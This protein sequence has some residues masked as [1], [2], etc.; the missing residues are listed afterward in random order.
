PVGD[1]IY[2]SGS[3]KVFSGTV[4][5][6][7]P[8]WIRLNSQTPA[9]TPGSFNSTLLTPTDGRY[10]VTIQATN[11]ARLTTTLNRMV[12][13]DSLF[14]FLET[15]RPRGADTT[16]T[17]AADTFA[18]V[19][20][21]ADTTLT[22][23]TLA[24]D[25]VASGQRGY[26]GFAHT[27]RLDPG[28]NVVTIRATDL[29]G[30]RT[31][32]TRRIYRKLSA[33]PLDSATVSATVPTSAGLV[34]FKESISFLYTSGSP[35]LQRG[36]SG[37]TIVEDRAAVVRGR[38]LSR[39]D[40]ALPAAR[41]SV[42]GHP[43]YGYT[44]SREDGWFDLA[45][46]G[47]TPLT[48]RFNKAGFLESQRQVN[49]AAND[50]T[51]VDDVALVG[52][53]AIRTV[54]NLTNGG[55]VRSRLST[56]ANGDRSPKLFFKAGTA[57]QVM[58]G[59]GTVSTFDSVRVRISEF[60]VGGDGLAAMPAGL[61]PSTAYTY[62]V[63]LSLDEADS[64]AAIDGLPSLETR[65]T[66]PVAHYLRNFLGAPVGGNI[67]AGYYDSRAAVWKADSDAVVIKIVG[68]DADTARVDVTGDGVADSAAVLISLG[69]D[70]EELVQLRRNFVVGDT[71]WRALTWHFSSPDLNPR[72]RPQPAPV[73]L[74][75]GKPKKQGDKLPCP[76]TASG[77]IIECES[78]VLGEA[79]PVVGTPYTLNY[80]SH[81]AQGYAVA[82]T[83]R[84][85]LWGSDT[86]PA[87]LRRIHVRLDVAGKRYEK[88]YPSPSPNDTAVVR[89]DGNDA[90]GRV[91]GNSVNA[92]ISLGY[93][94]TPAWGLTSRGRN[95]NNPSGS[96]VA[97]L[98]ANGDRDR[99]RISWSRQRIT[100]G[101]PDAS[102]DGLGG[103]TFSPHHFYDSKGRGALYRGDGSVVSGDFRPAILQQI[104]SGLQ[105]ISGTC[106]TFSTAKMRPNDLAFG[107]DGTMYLA[108]GLTHS[109][110]RVAAG[111]NTACRIAGTGSAG[112]FVT[113]RKG[114]ETP[115][116]YPSSLALG[117]DGSVYFTMG[118]TGDNCVRV[119]RLTPDDSLHSIAGVGTSGYSGDGGP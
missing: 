106:F 95:F 7:T 94:Y 2:T 11:S 99:G 25:T 101:T 14:P 4:G 79:I 97:F 71:L 6:E 49:P 73:A 65:F 72:Q 60:T 86:I 42:L 38:V 41:V 56:D 77:S 110:Y 52:K 96:V 10:P 115:I 46:N 102:S 12:I 70:V 108:D 30:H 43:E 59:N 82:R 80:R 40:V 13:R 111:T 36:V 103:W 91:V 109:I 87:D 57:A 39:D 9:A 53:S 100:L 117:P 104:T 107:P 24:G 44:L 112:T 118:A 3:T 31:A 69:F 88:A 16:I 35:P 76:A 92:E 113:H 33:D 81:R 19:G 66:K 61:P 119:C 64:L 98:G 116:T 37:A 74:G 90:F 48:L 34:E 47:G 28:M 1:T 45:L 78:C 83:V 114:T 105:T 84:I 26:V 15:F 21:F 32:I 62:C 27:Y 18:I 23:L 85:P 93:D 8:G 20:R 75:A 17:Q 63:D 68:L 54:V 50:Y 22:H 29:L 89:W 67:P 58:R 55:V 5:D 51:I